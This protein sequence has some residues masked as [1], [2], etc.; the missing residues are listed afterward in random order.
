MF[1][2]FLNLFVFALL[3]SNP[4][5]PRDVEKIIGATWPTYDSRDGKYLAIN[6]SMSVRNHFC[7]EEYNFWVNLIPK[8]IELSRQTDEGVLHFL[9]AD[10]DSCGSKGSCPP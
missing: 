7:A 4:N 6:R 10:Q 2:L 1:Y 5:K 9:K 3:H 8:V